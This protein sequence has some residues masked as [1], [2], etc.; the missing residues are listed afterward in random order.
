[1]QVSETGNRFVYGGCQL[2]STVFLQFLFCDRRGD[3]FAVFRFF[4]T[5][6]RMWYDADGLV[7][8]RQKIGQ[9]G[10]LLH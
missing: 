6:V 3:R 10:R 2:Q 5:G 1:M 8:M 7:Q 4:G 9:T